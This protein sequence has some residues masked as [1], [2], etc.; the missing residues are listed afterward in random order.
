MWIRKI[1]IFVEPWWS[2][3]VQL[4]NR[5][6]GKDIRKTKHFFPVLHI[7]IAAQVC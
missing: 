1:D 7:A 5:Q 3:Y 4:E 2:L 6:I